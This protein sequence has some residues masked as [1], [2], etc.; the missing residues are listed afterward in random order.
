MNEL[1]FSKAELTLLSE[2]TKNSNALV[3][4][5]T[6]AMESIKQNKIIQ[7]PF[8]A[9][10]NETVNE[11]AL[12]IVFNSA[13]HDEIDRIM[14]SVG[15]FFNAIDNRTNT[16]LK[17]TQDNAA[18][19]INMSLFSQIA[20]AL[21]IAFLLYFIIRTLFDPLQHA[22]NAMLNIGDGDGDLSLRLYEAGNNEL[23]TLGKGFNHFANHI[24]NVVIELRHSIEDIEASSMQLSSTANFTDQSVIEQ[25]SG[26]QQ[27]LVA[28]EQILP[29]VQ[30]IAHNA[31]LA[32][33]Q[34]KL[35][36]K[37]ASTGLN[38]IN[39]A[40]SNINLLET[41]I[42]NASKVINKLAH[43]SVNIGSVLDVIR[44]IA[45]Q[46]NLLALNAAIEAARAGEQGRG[47][48]V[49]ADEVRTLAKRTQDST[50]EI[51]KMIEILQKGAKDSVKVMELSKTRTAA[52]VQNTDEAGEFFKK[53]TDSVV[54]ITQI[55]DQIAAAT[56]EQSATLEEIRRTVETI[57]D[58][59]EHTSE[60]SKKTATNSQFT[61]QLAGKIKSL[62]NQFKTE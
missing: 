54:S 13:Y 42:E 57:N 41:D 20:V 46:T 52:C 55:N 6:Q 47:F 2:A 43:D 23:S 14:V 38:V 53:I 7:G 12:R 32:V 17:T 61:T 33:E 15:S 62:V 5:E 30:D 40:V 8:Q 22:I 48:A 27:L 9:L 58:H 21:L 26:I 60:G 3:A 28:L 1:N 29:A 34:A 45:D 4:T 31:T 18:F 49:V 59:V 51:Q 11:F 35:S 37:A 19:W 24:Q 25:K 36:D 16:E 44:G 56:D 39:E 10:P 50:T